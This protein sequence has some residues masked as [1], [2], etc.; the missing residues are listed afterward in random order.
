MNFIILNVEM[1]VDIFHWL[2]LVISTT[3]CAT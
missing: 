2:T 3:D 1:G